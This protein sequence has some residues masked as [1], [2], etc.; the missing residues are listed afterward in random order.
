MGQRF[1]RVDALLTSETVGII[2][3]IRVGIAS[4]VG[5]SIHCV[6]SRLPR[7]TLHPGVVDGV[8]NTTVKEPA[9][10]TLIKAHFPGGIQLSCGGQGCFFLLTAIERLIIR[11][12]FTDTDVEDLTLDIQRNTEK[13][14]SVGGLRIKVKKKTV[15]IHTIS[16]NKILVNQ[17]F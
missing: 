2:F 9:S 10:T 3:G 16:V 6:H 8:T 15:G 13:N 7:P 17:I 14:V 12:T 5:V 11:E 4:L 1:D